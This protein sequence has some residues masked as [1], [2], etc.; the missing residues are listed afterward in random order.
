MNFQLTEIK[1]MRKKLGLTQNE[2][3]MSSG[4]SQSLIAKIESNKIDPTYT[5]ALKIF[6]VLS[7]LGK[8][9]GLVAK[10]IA[11]QNIISVSLNE[12]LSNVIKKMKDN[13]ISQVPVISNGVIG[14]VSESC[15]LD[16]I[17]AGK[18]IAIMKASDVMEKSPPIISDDSDVDVVACL[19]KY[20]P[21]I[22]TS[23]NGRISG[24]ITKADLLNKMYKEA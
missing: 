3:A 23:K 24:I 10:D 7:M 5:N 6:N 13:N 8:K 21:I 1:L 4:V 17:H 15:I 18:D 16:P 2:L 22:I 14:Y 9:D 19:L 12:K 20:Y 11:N